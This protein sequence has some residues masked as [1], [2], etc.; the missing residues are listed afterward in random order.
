MIGIYFTLKQWIQSYRVGDDLS[1]IVGLLFAFQCDMHQQQEAQVMSIKRAIVTL[2]ISLLLVSW[3]VP[4]SAAE[5]PLKVVLEDAVYGGLIGSLIGTATLAFVDHGSDHL[6]NIAIG[7]A[8]GIMAGTGYGIYTAANRS[9]VEY[10]NGRVKFAIP[11]IKP[12]IQETQ[13][14]ELVLAVKADLLHGTF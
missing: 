3:T 4:V 14:G 13:K 8:L 12:D 10:E 2:I 7:G 11:L 1:V 5:S 9:L 6:E